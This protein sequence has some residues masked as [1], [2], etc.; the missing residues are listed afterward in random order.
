M[1]G[2]RLVELDGDLAVTVVA[3]VGGQDDVRDRYD[4]E[5][6]AKGARKLDRF[7]RRAFR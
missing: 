3:A 1:L 5:R 2:L 7:E 6:S 4:D